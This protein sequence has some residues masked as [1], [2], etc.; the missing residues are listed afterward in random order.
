MKVINFL[1]GVSLM[2]NNVKKMLLLFV[3]ILDIPIFLPSVS[4]LM[5]SLDKEWVLFVFILSKIQLTQNTVTQQKLVSWVLISTQP[6]LDSSLLVFM[7]EQFWYMISEINIKNLFIILLSEPKNTLTLYGKLDGT[8]ISLR[9]II[10]IPFL[11]MVELWI[12]LLWKINLNP[13]KSFNLN[14]PEE[15]VMKKP[16]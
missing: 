1:F 10:S 9:N 13:K 2:K 3:G 4:V 6:V 12:G 8:L 11:V 7:T 14:L 15:I 16:I 5:I